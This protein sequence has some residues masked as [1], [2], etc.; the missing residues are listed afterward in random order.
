MHESV[1]KIHF[2]INH[3]GRPFENHDYMRPTEKPIESHQIGYH[4]ESFQKKC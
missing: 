1:Q 4:I 2:L 3:D